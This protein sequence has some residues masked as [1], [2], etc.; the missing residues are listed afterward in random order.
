M[1]SV[2]VLILVPMMSLLIVLHSVAHLN[3]LHSTFYLAEIDNLNQSSVSPLS[4]LLP[5]VA[6]PPTSSCHRITSPVLIS[7]LPRHV[8]SHHIS[9]P[10]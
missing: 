3:I 9:F 8:I 10:P 2:L 7:S 6:F 1:L 5:I 4:L